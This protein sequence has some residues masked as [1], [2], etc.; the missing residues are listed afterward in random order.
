ML[1]CT[2]IRLEVS[3]QDATTLEFMQGKCRGLYNWWI[4]K[5]RNG[6]R[7]PG[8]AGAKKTLQESKQHDPELC[9]VYGKLLAEVYFRLDGAMQA[10]FRRLKAGENPGFPRVRPRHCFFTLVYPSMYIKV[11]GLSLRLPTG[12]KG[13]N[14]KHPDILANLTEEAP[15]GY[16]EVAISRDAR[17]HYYASFVAEQEEGTCDNNSVV[18]FDLGIKTLATGVN[19]QGKV[20]RV[21][22]FKGAGWYNHQLDKI[23]SKRDRCKKKSRRYRY[24]SNV[25][26]RV[27]EKKRSKQRDSLHKASHLIARRMV[28]RTVVVGN[29]SQR[30]M[31]M[32]EHR[33]RNKHLN[34]AV[35]NEWGLYT[36]IQM[37]LY[38]C[39][40]Y[41]K[42]L[43]I[44]DERDTSKNC[45]GCGHK[46]PMPL[47]K[48]TYHCK[49]C[50][51]VMDRDEN[52]AHNILMRFLARLGP[53][54]PQECGVLHPDQNS[55]GVMEM[56]CPTDV[57]QLGLW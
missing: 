8:W 33:E 41:G 48:R 12:G 50:G 9:Q 15:A 4:C 30:Q 13:K 57:Q 21:G 36:F 39:Q 35:F 44:V 37:L 51:L 24:L 6:E 3:S 40:L 11:D 26:K 56:P 29:L 54:T 18:A 27:S 28:E 49:E 52:S 42:D 17:G 34:R 55:V 23:R 7:W 19:E 43:Q 2:K 16:K 1:L 47:W 46:Q 14:K 5:L 25:Y 32:K 22:G 20:Y 38:K 53:H 31:V 45:S 10:F